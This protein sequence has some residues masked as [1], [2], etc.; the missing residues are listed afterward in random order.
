MKKWSVLHGRFHFTFLLYDTMVQ[1][2][3]YVCSIFFIL[4]FQI[5]NTNM[6]THI[7]FL[8]LVL[9]ALCLSC[10]APPMV[11]G[12]GCNVG[13][14]LWG[15]HARTRIRYSV[16]QV[17]NV[18]T[19]LCCEALACGRLY[20]SRCGSFGWK[21]LGCSTSS[22]SG[23]LP[24]GNNVAQPRVRCKGVPFGTTYQASY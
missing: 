11:M 4:I 19:M 22:I 6:S 3:L 16:S 18:G 17:N 12:P 9:P 15:S 7:V 24:W 21:N 14:T 23:T 1:C 20:S 2:N 13:P 5:K 8:L 10:Y